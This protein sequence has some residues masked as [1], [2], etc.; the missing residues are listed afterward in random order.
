M[1][2][3]ERTVSALDA[4]LPCFKILNAMLNGPLVTND[5][6]FAATRQVVADQINIAEDL[7][8]L[9][10]HYN[11]FFFKPLLS[12]G[13]SP[14]GSRTSLAGSDDSETSGSASKCIRR[15]QVGEGPSS[16]LSGNSLIRR[17]SIRSMAGSVVGQRQS[18][19]NNQVRKDVR[20]RDVGCCVLTG[21]S[22]MVP[23]RA[24][25]HS[26]EVAHIVPHSLMNQSAEIRQFIRAICPW[27]PEDFFSTI[28][29]CE[30]AILLNHGAH[31]FFGNFQWFITMEENMDPN[32]SVYRATEVNDTGLLGIFSM[33]REEATDNGCFRRIS[34]FNQ[35]LFI[36]TSQPR[37]AKV[38]LKLH[39]LISRIVHMRGAAEPNEE[40]TDDDQEEIDSLLEM[41]EMSVE[42]K[43]HRFITSQAS[44]TTLDGHNQPIF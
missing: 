13:G 7:N 17:G 38:F 23:G 21:M 42:E 4:T 31:T 20:D 36:G 39:E 18:Y 27:I 35:V 22:E 44:A 2:A 30:N 43:V 10:E 16:P 19:R 37:P 8:L 15:S 41:E 34:S 25:K 3:A 26:F 12:N 14:T 29:R 9:V 5:A 11:S 1:E 40:D 28:D 32:M 24:E 33:G 6:D